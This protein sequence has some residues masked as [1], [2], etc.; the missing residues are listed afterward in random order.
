MHLHF[1]RSLWLPALKKGRQRE[2]E[3]RGGT[4]QEP[5]ERRMEWRVS[6]GQ[7][8][9]PQRCLH[10]IPGTSCGHRGCGR[11]GLGGHRWNQCMDRSRKLSLGWRRGQAGDKNPKSAKER[12]HGPRGHQPQLKGLQG[13][14]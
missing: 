3:T 4:R 6:G 12:A 9:D 10:L 5:R 11:L 13:G 14:V 2:Q 7:N 1:K 8:N